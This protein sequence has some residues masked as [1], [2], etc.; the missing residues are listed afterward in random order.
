[1][2]VEMSLNSQ[3]S[4]QAGHQER[5]GNS[6]AT[7]VGQGNHQARGAERNEIVVI[8]AYGARGAAN[9][10]NIEAGHRGQRAWK[11]LLLH[12]SRNRKLVLETLLLPLRFKQI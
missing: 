11:K 4:L 1:M 12:F 6:L 7:D 3:R 8:A 2:A 10:S 9:R 5:R